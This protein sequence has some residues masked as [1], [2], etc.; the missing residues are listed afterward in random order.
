MV[1]KPNAGIYLPAFLL[2][3]ALQ[4]RRTSEGSAPVV[5]ASLAAAVTSAILPIVTL[6]W[7]WRDGVLAETWVAL[8]DFNRMYVAEGFELRTFAI[9]FAKAVWLRVKSDPLWLAGAMGTLLAGWNLL[10]TRTL[11]P[12]LSLAIVWGGAAAIVIV[13]NGARLYSTYF[14]QAL[15]PL[16]VLAAWLLAGAPARGRTHRLVALAAAVLMLLLMARE[17]FPRKV[18]EF[19]RADLDQLLGRTDRAAY[20]ETFGGY[21]N[22]RG[23]SARANDELAAYVAS[24]TTR[25][26]CIYLFGMNSGVYFATDRLT[27]H[28]FLRVTPFAPPKFP[29]PGFQLPVVTREIAARRPRYLIFERFDPRSVV[30]AALDAL[31]RQPDIR[32]LLEGYRLETRIEDFTL[33]RRID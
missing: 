13:A 9:D 7:L 24:R 31:D 10:R 17:S 1:Y 4:R 27:A 14:L 8:V 18:Y 30:G 23:Y 29:D 6:L 19:A 5:R 28:R 25:E 22:G 11:D 12:T 2:W 3:V 20:L 21:A 32:R 15:A 33:Y 16:A 26:E